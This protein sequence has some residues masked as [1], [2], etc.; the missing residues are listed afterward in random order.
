[1]E[2][3][4]SIASN[5]VWWRNC[6]SGDFLHPAQ[7]EWRELN[8]APFTPLFF[9]WKTD[10]IHGWTDKITVRKNGHFLSLLTP[11]LAQL[12]TRGIAAFHALEKGH[13]KV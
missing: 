13:R 10:K 4:T 11:V 2:M 6:V 9:G 8:C 1:M 12:C 5:R 7:I 3:G